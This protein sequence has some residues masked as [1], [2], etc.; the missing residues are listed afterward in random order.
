MLWMLAALVIP[1]LTGLILF[2]SLAND[3]WQLITFRLDFSRLF[4]DLFH[5]FF[6]LLIAL[7]LEGFV[8]FHVAE[9]WL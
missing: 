2:F 4:G 5:I 6:I 7:L 8:L 9:T 3:F 1:V